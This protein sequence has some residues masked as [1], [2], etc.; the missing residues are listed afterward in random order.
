ME[1]RLARINISSAGGTA[2]NGA[3][4]YK[5]TIPS[6]W[7]DRLGISEDA[8]SVELTLDGDRI[9]VEKLLTFPEFIR[10]AKEKGHDVRLYL[11]R[12]EEML[13]SAIAADFSVQALQVE[14]FTDNPVKTAFGKNTLP[15]W[16]DFLAFLEER[17]VPRQRAGIR[18]FLEA[19]GLDSYDPVAI[20][21]KT[22]GRMAEDRQWI[23][24][25]KP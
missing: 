22:Q 19:L 6:A 21:G 12:D 25:L 14:N 16:A 7:I 8:R 13:C 4:T 17:C 9:I 15:V 10:C 2:G 3:K 18:E 11:F 1:K 23:E 20:I 5:L 24:E